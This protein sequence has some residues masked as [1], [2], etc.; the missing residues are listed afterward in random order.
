[1]DNFYQKNHGFTLL[2]LLIALSL[3]TVLMTV[4]V[5]GL[6]QITHDWEK[7]GH[8]LDAKIDES[9]LLLQLEKAILGTYAYRVK[10]TS[11]SKESLFF[12][13]TKTELDWVSTVSPG[14]DSSLMYWHLDIDGDSG[15]KLDI[16]PAYPGDL[17]KQLDKAKVQAGQKP[18]VYFKEY[19][20]SLHYL[21]ETNNQKKQWQTH[22]SAKEK[23]KLPIGVRIQF[24]QIGSNPAIDFSVFSFI[25]VASIKAG[26]RRTGNTGFGDGGPNNATGSNTGNNTQPVNNPFQTIL[27]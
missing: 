24:E 5:V 13:G 2:E 14:R 3:S 23:D 27:N 12:E 11:V 8:A 9:L 20:I 18:L 25:R 22:W 21:V 17:R 15:F 1:M 26:L 4:L 6:R 7:H 10:K 16:V 19:K